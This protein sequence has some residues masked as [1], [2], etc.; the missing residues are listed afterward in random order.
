V[1]GRPLTRTL[2]LAAAV[3]FLLAGILGFVPG[4]TS[5][6]GDLGFAGRGSRAQLLGVFQVSVLLNLLHLGLGV[7]GL[8]LARARDAAGTYLVG[9]GA[10]ALAVWLL[11]VVA[12]GGW[13]PVDTADNWL[14]F[15]LG[16]AMVALGGWAAGREAA[17]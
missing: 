8:V 7:A 4:V 13:L 2:A 10:V 9:G 12:A 11:G 3:V 5:D 14:H 16:L 17:R 1:A 6:Y 15:V